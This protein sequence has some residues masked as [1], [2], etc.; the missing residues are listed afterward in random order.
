LH[1]DHFRSP[2]RRAAGRA[3]FRIAAA[4]NFGQRSEQRA[5]SGREPTDWGCEA[6]LRMSK[7][8]KHADPAGLRRP[9]ADFRRPLDESHRSLAKARDMSA[10]AAHRITVRLPNGKGASILYSG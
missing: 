10:S 2:T 9:L 3:S 1:G 7:P 4:L 8:V 6:V 5:S